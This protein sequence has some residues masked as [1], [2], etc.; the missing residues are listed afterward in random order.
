MALI[1]E[2]DAL[3]DQVDELAMCAATLDDWRLVDARLS[4]ALVDGKLE[5][6]SLQAEMVALVKSSK[7]NWCWF[8][9]H[10]RLRELRELLEDLR[11]LRM[12]VQ[13]RIYELEQGAMQVL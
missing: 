4:H 8:Q 6:A 5:I 13:S 11:V 1:D 3:R 10:S 12:C 9:T 7:P 2:A